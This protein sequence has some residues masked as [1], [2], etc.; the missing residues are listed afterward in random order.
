MP[1]ANPT[2][3]LQSA[4]AAGDFGQAV[5]TLTAMLAQAPRDP[6]LHYNLGAVYGALNDSQKAKQHLQEAIGLRPTMAEAHFAM[7]NLQARHGENAAAIHSYRAAL[8]ANPNFAEAHVNLAAVHVAG[9]NIGAA[10]EHYL[11]ADT[12]AP[13]TPLILG[14]IAQCYAFTGQTEKALE[15]AIKAMLADPSSTATTQVAKLLVAAGR[16]SHAMVLFQEHAFRADA[17]V[18]LLMSFG[19]M[20][21]QLEQRENALAAYDVC[22]EHYPLVVVE[23]TAPPAPWARENPFTA[24]NPGPRYGTLIRQYEILHQ[25]AQAKSKNGGQMFEGF[26][27]F[28]IVAPHVRRFARMLNAKTMLDYGGG[29]GAQYRLGKITVGQDAFPTSLAYLGIDQ[30][31]CFDPGFNQDLSADSFDLVICVDALEHCDRKDL[32]WIIRRLFQKARLG[33]FA[34]IAS[35]PA[36]KVLPN[37]ENAHCTVEDAGWWMSL[38]RAVADDFPNVHYQVIVSKDLRQSTRIAFGR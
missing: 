30:A 32:P 7:G 4:I 26:V 29:R 5:K 17:T 8:G 36:G 34:N 22:A 35:Y 9:K 1:S 14:N 25:E 2:Q 13:R 38:F 23:N 33:V 20:F 27:G 37:G 10:L 31:V 24:D 18:D 16:Q 12:L 21:T 15:F 11:T 6:S 19:Q 3:E 28:A